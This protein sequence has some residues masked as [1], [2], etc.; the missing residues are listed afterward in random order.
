MHSH[1]QRACRMLVLPLLL[2]LLLLLQGQA[3]SSAV[4]KQK[5]GHPQPALPVDVYKAKQ[6]LAWAVQG[7][8][9]F[10]HIVVC[11]KGII[12]GA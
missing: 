7:A 11:V 2:L 8:T 6:P 10:M 5:P 12:K 1:P 4:S 9:T 3:G